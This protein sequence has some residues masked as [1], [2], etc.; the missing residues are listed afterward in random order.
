MI[1]INLLEIFAV[2]NPEIVDDII[3]R[4]RERADEE[5]NFHR[6]RRKHIPHHNRQG[7][8]KFGSCRFFRVGS[9]HDSIVPEA[10]VGL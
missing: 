7:F 4:L 1:D 6:H 10:F 5:F 9:A 3:H 2:F 8:S